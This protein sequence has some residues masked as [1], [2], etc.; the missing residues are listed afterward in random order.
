M[1]LRRNTLVT[2]GWLMKNVPKQLKPR[3]KTQN[4]DFSVKNIIKVL[5]SLWKVYLTFVKDN[6]SEKKLVGQCSSPK[7]MYVHVHADKMPV[8]QADDSAKSA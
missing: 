2:Y 3:R 8:T 6:K 1:L 4:G 5:V 7:Y